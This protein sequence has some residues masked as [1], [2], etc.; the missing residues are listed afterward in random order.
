M[1]WSARD[2]E[3]FIGFAL[4][5]RT[6]FDGEPLLHLLLRCEP[7]FL[8]EDAPWVASLLQNECEL[9]GPR[10]GSALASLLRAE[11]PEDAGEGAHFQALLAQ[12]GRADAD[13]RTPLM[14]LCARCPRLLIQGWA[15]VLLDAAGGKTDAG[16]GTALLALLSGAAADVDFEGAHFRRL[17]AAESGV[18]GPRGETL[19][20]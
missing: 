8:R 14:E 16:G 5:K 13:G 6:R 19:L 7:C 12:A 2:K 9:P 11:R 3:L 20:A 18:A 4:R 1:S 17:F 15:G 10:G